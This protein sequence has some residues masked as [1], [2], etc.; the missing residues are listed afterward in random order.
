MSLCFEGSSFVCNIKWHIFH[1]TDFKRWTHFPC[2]ILIKIAIVARCALCWGSEVYTQIN[3]YNCMLIESDNNDKGQVKIKKNSHE[4]TLFQ[5]QS[6]G[7]WHVVYMGSFNKSFKRCIYLFRICIR[8]HFFLLIF[9]FFTIFFLSFL[10]FFYRFGPVCPQRLP[11]IAN[12][13]AALEKMPKG[14]LEYLRRLL[15]YLQN[16]SEDCL[17][18]NIYVPIQGKFRISICS[19]SCFQSF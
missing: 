5:S 11:N 10:P 13:T 8:K 3:V 2:H 12:E 6:N 9:F 7:V 14:R 19:I 4:F 16:Q 15:P 1:L 18:L 17:Y